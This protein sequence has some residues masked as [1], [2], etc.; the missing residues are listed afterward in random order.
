MVDYSLI[1]QRADAGYAKAATRLGPPCQQFRASGPNTPLAVALGSLNVWATTDAA[2]KGATP[3]QFG[4]PQWYAA[5]ERAGLAVGDYLVGPQG[6]FFVSSLDYPGPVGLIYCNRTINAARALDELPDGIYEPGGG[7]SIATAE[8]FMAGWPASVL[9]IGSG[10]KMAST[11]MNLPT[12]AKLPGIAILLPI[13]APQLCFNDLV[14]DDLGQRY[15]IAS[16]ECSALG[17][18][19]TG[20]MQPPG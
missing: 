8:P 4:K 6:T 1:Q 9:Q 14:T 5:V 3:M 20:M 2:L 12:D 7:N 17:W 13:T 18:R 15:A 19:L 10:S 11:G 16:A